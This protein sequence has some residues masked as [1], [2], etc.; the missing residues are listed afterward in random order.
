MVFEHNSKNVKYPSQLAIFLGL[1][2]AGLV[3]GSLAIGAVWTMLT[4]RSVLT[5]EADMLKPEYYSAITAV[6]VVST[7][8]IFFVPAHF[9]ALICYRKPLTYLGFNFR[10]SGKQVMLMIGILILTFPLSASLSE[11][12]KMI[13]LTEY[14]EKKFKA[15]ELVREAQEAVLININSFSRYIISLIVIAL[16]PAIFEET[17]FRG[18][19]Q[20]LFTRWF[21]GPWVAI[22]LTAIIFSLIHL[23]F[24]GFLVRFVL[25]LVLGFIFYYSGSVWLSILFHFL[26]NGIQV[27]ALY[28]MTVNGIKN[29]N[30]EESF[31]LWAGAIALL[32]L[33][34]LFN[35]YKQHSEIHQSKY[36]EEITP[37]DEFHKWTANNS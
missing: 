30:I 13:P 25:G 4:N 15:W 7:F 9:F 18:G 16:L 12:N 34:Y 1:T 5:M 3:I 33:V 21:K 26:F 27:T 10:F 11:L 6:Q 2:G 37:D 29:K 28:I 22:I 36:I 20:N 8:F 23:S 35:L 19:L 31:P 32:L 24:Y 17:F 14:W